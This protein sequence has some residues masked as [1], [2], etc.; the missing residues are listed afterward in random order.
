MRDVNAYGEGTRSKMVLSSR[1][2]HLQTSFAVLN[3]W[4]D[5]RL[6]AFRV[7]L[8]NQ[9]SVPFSAFQPLGLT[10]KNRGF[11][12]HIEAY[13]FGKEGRKGREFPTELLDL[14]IRSFVC[15]RSH[16]GKISRSSRGKFTPRG[17]MSRAMFFFGG[18]PVTC[19]RVCFGEDL[20]KGLGGR[21]K[22]K[23]ESI[24]HPPFLF[25]FLQ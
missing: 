5:S 13:L 7:F 14:S 23:K 16:E 10:R 8:S 17:S 6:S 19:A 22:D 21:G 24:L 9:T 2:T 25:C 3:Q 1:G 4:R 18:P 20:E 15:C 11:Q 12:E